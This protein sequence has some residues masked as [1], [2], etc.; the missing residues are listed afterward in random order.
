MNF[1]PSTNPHS[2]FHSPPIFL[3]IWQTFCKGRFKVSKKW[4]FNLI[5][6]SNLVFCASSNR[7]ASCDSKM[8]VT[9]S[10]V[11]LILDNDRHCWHSELLMT[12]NK[13]RILLMLYIIFISFLGTTKYHFLCR[14]CIAMSNHKTIYNCV[15]AFEFSLDSLESWLQMVVFHFRENFGNC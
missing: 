1:S 13:M 10:R 6:S 7:K 2:W 4:S 14:S 8:F 12:D 3:M 15:V 5:G 9:K 11:E